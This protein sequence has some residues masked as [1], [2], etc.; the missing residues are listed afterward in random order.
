MPAHGRVTGL[1]LELCE[2][3]CRLRR[4][5]FLPLP[6]EVGEPVPQ[7][8][9]TLVGVEDAPDHEL[10][11]DRPVPA[12]LLEPERDVEAAVAPQPVE[13]PTLPERDR[14]TGVL[15]AVPDAEPEVLPLAYRLE[16]RELAAGQEEGHVRV[17]EPERGKPRELPAKLERELRAADDG[18]DSRHRQQVGLRDH[19]VRVPSE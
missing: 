2:N 3:R 15:A 7:P 18:I 6:P 13:L 14:R 17:A 16:L 10:R 4:P 12:V 1:E 8:E 19:S 9:E 5:G 11:R